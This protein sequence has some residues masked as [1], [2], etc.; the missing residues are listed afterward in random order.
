M[1]LVEARAP[2]G[3]D[4]HR[5]RDHG[6]RASGDRS[7]IQTSRRLHID[8]TNRRPSL[9]HV[10]ILI[11]SPPG[12]ARSSSSTLRCPDHVVGATPSGEIRLI[13]I[14]GGSFEGEELH[15]EILGGGADWQ[16][17][18]NDGVLEISA[19]YCSTDRAN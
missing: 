8:E 6:R 1:T 13:P 7:E 16:D 11:A 2:N 19:R 5:R 15:G 10:R 9:A 17:V 12:F 18:R 14:T 4:R 3:F